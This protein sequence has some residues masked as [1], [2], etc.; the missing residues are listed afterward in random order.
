MATKNPENDDQY[1]NNT[2]TNLEILQRMEKAFRRNNPEEKRRNTAQSMKWFSRY[3]P[4][5]MNNARTSQL[6]RDRKL[7]KNKITPGKL[8]FFEYDPIHKDKLPV[9]DRFPMV[10]CWDMWRGNNGHNYFICLNLHYLPPKLRYVVMKQLLSFR[11]E[12][13]YR[14]STKLSQRKNDKDAPKFAW[15]TLKSM[16]NSKY[17]ENCVH[18]YRADHVKSAFIEVPAQSWELALWLPVQRFEKGGKSVAWD[19]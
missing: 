18:M 11:Q 4:R 9:Y 12:T 3:V 5:S 2:G 16:S 14:K 19:I 1:I 10:F 7:W 6:M 13:K 17:F 15:A 8:T